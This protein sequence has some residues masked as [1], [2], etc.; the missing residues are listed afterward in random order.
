MNTGQM[1]IGIAAFALVTMTILNFNRGSI[2]TQDVL[3]YNKAFIVATT[4]AKSTL[5]EISKM[6]FDEEIVEGNSIVTAND[7]SAV[8]GAESSEV[9]PNFDD[10]DDYNNFTKIESVPSIGSFNVSVEVT[11]MTDDL[12]TTT[13]KTYNKNV[14]VKI[15]SKIMANVFTDKVDT[16]IISSLFSQWKML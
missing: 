7:F 8:L 9:Y 15:T 10:V 2:N 11:Y 6:E 13:A 5:D 4:I 12:V 16:V 14:T 1:M 3:I